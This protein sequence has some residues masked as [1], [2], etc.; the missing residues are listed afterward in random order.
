MSSLP[1][2]Q[3]S[4]IRALIPGQIRISGFV[5]LSCKYHREKTQE[6]SHF[7]ETCFSLTLLS[8]VIKMLASLESHLGF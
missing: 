6:G 8:Q 1:Y 2:P 7:R 4:D 5:A 3:L